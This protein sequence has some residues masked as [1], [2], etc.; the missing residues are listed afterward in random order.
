MLEVHSVTKMQNRIQRT[1]PEYETEYTDFC[2][3]ESTGF[4]PGALHTGSTSFVERWR[5]EPVVMRD[6]MRPVKLL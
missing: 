2:F 5:G 4:K 1:L 6:V 3:F